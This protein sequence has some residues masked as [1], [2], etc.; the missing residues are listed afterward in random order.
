MQN[1]NN[2][3]ILGWMKMTVKWNIINKIYCK[4]KGTHN[5]MPSKENIGKYKEIQGYCIKGIWQS[6]IL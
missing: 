6:N 1:N 3:R 4:L 2:S 5:Q